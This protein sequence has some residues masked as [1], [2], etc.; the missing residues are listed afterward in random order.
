VD[1][2]Y[3]ARCILA[4]G[5]ETSAMNY[6]RK[7]DAAIVET[8]STK[9][10]SLIHNLLKDKQRILEYGRKAWECGKRNHQIEDLQNMLY[11]DFCKAINDKKK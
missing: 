6:L 4:I 9:F 11:N 8:D 5:G 3:N 2:F 1:Y 7:N 10:K